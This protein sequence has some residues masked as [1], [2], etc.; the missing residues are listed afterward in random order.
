MSTTFKSVMWNLT[1]IAREWVRGSVNTKM[2]L[3]SYASFPPWLFFFLHFSFLSLFLVRVNILVM[4][5]SS[6]ITSHE[7][8]QESPRFSVSFALFFIILSW[9]SYS[10]VERGLDGEQG[11]GGGVGKKPVALAWITTTTTTNFIADYKNRA[12]KLNWSSSRLG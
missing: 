4:S 3:A 7:W 10:L 1:E 12:T 6:G 8:G 9:L 11:E 5:Y 2:E